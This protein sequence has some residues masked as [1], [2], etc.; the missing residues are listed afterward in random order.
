MTQT[1]RLVAILAANLA[2]SRRV[3]AAEGYP[4]LLWPLC[5]FRLDLSATFRPA[6]SLICGTG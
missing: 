4:R 2:Q 6:P 3:F 1:R 5:Q